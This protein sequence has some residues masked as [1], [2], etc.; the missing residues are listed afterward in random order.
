M[1]ELIPEIPVLGMRLGRNVEH[2]DR[3][4]EFP[5]PRAAG[6]LRTV[7]HPRLLPA[8]D[9]GN[10][11]SCTAHAAFG[12]MCT[13]PTAIWMRPTEAQII[14]A[15][16]WETAHD[17]FPGQYPP[18][19]TGSSGLAACKYLQ[20]RGWITGYDHAFGLQ[21]A[22]E[23]LQIRPVI[24]GVT[25]Y[26]SFDEPA[27][28]GLVRITPG[29]WVRGAHEFVVSGYFAEYG[30]VECCNS[31]GEGWGKSGKFYMLIS[32]WDRLLH[33]NGDVTTVWR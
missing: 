32:D 24:T 13:G 16:S 4:K 1:I 9:Q 3:S 14:E 20:A 23:A 30:I 28:N 22:L 31:W 11:G 10:L 25:W 6:P 17:E 5:A 18:T 7:I 21:H 2:D 26:S 27:E 29:A 15:Y 19:D 8:F 33:E 12:L